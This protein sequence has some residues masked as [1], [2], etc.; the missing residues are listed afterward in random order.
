[1]TSTGRAP[2]QITPPPAEGK[3]MHLPQPAVAAPDDYVTEELLVAGTATS[4]DAGETPTDGR[5]TAAPGTEADYRTRVIVRRPAS[6]ARFSGTVIVEWFNVSAIEASPD[7]AFMAP[8]IG[9]EGDIYIG[10]SAQAQG[11]EGGATLIDVRV[12]PD[13]ANAAGVT[14]DVSG[15]KHIDPERYG[16]LVHPGDAYA[17]DIF[18]QVGRAAK[19]SAAQLLGGLEP[20]HVIAVGESQSAAFM[21]TFVNAV[22]PLSPAFDGFLIHSRGGGA[23]PLDGDLPAARGTDHDFLRSGVRVRTDLDVPVFLFETETDLTLLGYAHARQPDTDRVRTWEV[24]GLA[25]ADAHFVRA[26]IGGPRDPNIGQLLGSSEPI[27]VG[28]QHEVIQAA[29]HHLVD[30]VRGGPPPPSGTTIQLTD[31]GDIT[32]ARDDHGIALGGVRHPL[33]DVPTAALSGEPPGGETAADLVNGRG[34]VSVLFGSTTPFD[35]STLLALYP[36]ADDYVTAFTAS[37]NQAVAAGY[38]LRPDADALVAEAE[39][40]RALFD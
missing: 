13:Q 38:L 15:L 6:A 29:L 21:T 34:G 12:D 4:F 18:A 3:G 2:D 1:M 28:P 19:R 33:V 14:S 35:H 24:A 36:T 25:H 11:V 8:E 27:N 31:A 20:T 7:W 16:S 39:A 32:I 5:W 10:V 26:I 30:W 9:R 40:N 17:F 23:A 37:A 22:Q